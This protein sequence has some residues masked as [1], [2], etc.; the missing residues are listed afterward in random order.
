MN[1]CYRR[2][3]ADGRRLHYY[4]CSGEYPN[5]GKYCRSFAGGPLDAAVVDAVLARLA[6]PRIVAI[7][8]AWQAVRDY[9]RDSYRLETTLLHR[10]RRQVEEI[11]R[12]YMSVDPTNRLV[13]AGLESQL[14]HAKRELLTREATAGDRS[15][16]N[17]R[18]VA[19]DLREL[20][21]LVSDIRRLFEAPTT[22]D[23]DRKQILRMLIDHVGFEG[24]SE[25]WTSARIFWADDH[26]DTVLRVQGCG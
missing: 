17:E 26:P 25:E 8:E 20:E 16:R 21:H 5:G 10:A 18:P 11:E 1:T 13:A 6:P 3:R 15:S 14:E 4:G 9:E 22:T 7:R 2:Q 23:R 19:A 12:R 24:R